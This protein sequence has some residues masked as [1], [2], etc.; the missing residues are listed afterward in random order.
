M[1]IF[2]MVVH[3]IVCLVLIL[4]ILLQAGRGGGLSDMIGGSQSQSLFGTQTNVFLTRATEVCAVMF[5]ITSLTLGMMSTHRGRS[6]MEKQNLTR[7]IKTP[8]PVAAPVLPKDAEVSEV[9]KEAV[10]PE[11]PATPATASD[12]KTPVEGNAK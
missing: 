5:I 6:L 12:A 4:A 8:V 1:Y 11:P 7:A 9:P 3:V 10:A 2:V